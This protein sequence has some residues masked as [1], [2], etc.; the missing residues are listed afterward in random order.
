MRPNLGGRQKG[1][2][3]KKRTKTIF[4]LTTRAVPV[5]YVIRIRLIPP[6]SEMSVTFCV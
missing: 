6:L 3:G 5:R 4:Y 2:E 1:H